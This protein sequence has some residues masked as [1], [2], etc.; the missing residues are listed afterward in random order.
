MQEEVSRQDLSERLSLIEAM[1]A[2]GR[3]K[4]ESWGWT[5]VLWGVAYYVAIAW[6][7]W[8]QSPSIWG[9]NYIAWPVT[10]IGAV[11]VTM[12]IGM[13]K[14]QRQTGT[15]ISRAMMSIWMA[16]GVSMMLIFPALG[17]SGRMDQHV[18]VALVAAMLGV[19]NGASGL[20]LKWKMQ[21]A[22]AAVWWAT[23]VVACFGSDTQLTVVF[24]VALFLCQ[25]VFGIYAMLLESRRRKQYGAVHA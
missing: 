5:F 2:E 15:T 14:G 22:C 21:V 6:A 16:V 18:F 4:T 25:I 9:G 23:S 19:A 13:M 7:T 12:A 11:L 1:I 8:G 20:I 24:L 17:Y 3:H 10:M